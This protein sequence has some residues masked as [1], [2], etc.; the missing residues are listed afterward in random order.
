MKELRDLKDLTI[1]P[2]REQAAARTS[3]IRCLNAIFQAP[4]LQLLLSS[5]L[6]SSL[7]LSYTEV[8]EP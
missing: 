3:A 4:T 2:D 5:L 8:Y 1:H 6:L 7:E